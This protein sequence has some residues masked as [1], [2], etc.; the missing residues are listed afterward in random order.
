MGV[1]VEAASTGRVSRAVRMCVKTASG[2]ILPTGR[3]TGVTAVL[4]FQSVQR[5][6]EDSS[7]RNYSEWT[8]D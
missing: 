2:Y 7:R 3:G 5:G 6:C 1:R 8:D 4:P